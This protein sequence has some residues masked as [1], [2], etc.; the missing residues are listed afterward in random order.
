MKKTIGLV[1]LL[2][3]SSFM[4]AQDYFDLPT[5]KAFSFNPEAGNYIMNWTTSSDP[6]DEWRISRVAL[7]D[8]F[9]F[10]GSQ[11]NSSLSTDRKYALWQKLPFESRGGLPSDFNIQFW[12]YR[13]MVALWVDGGGAL[14]LPSASV[15]DACHR[16]GIKAMANITFADPTWPTETRWHNVFL[17][18]DQNKY[19]HA[20]KLVEILKHYGLDGL[21]VNFEVTSMSSTSTVTSTI[22]KEWLQAVKDEAARLGMTGFEI[23]SYYVW[24]NNGTRSWTIPGIHSDNSEWMK[25]NNKTTTTMALHNYPWSQTWISNSVT[26][27]A[28]IGISSYDSYMGLDFYLR[29]YNN[30]LD[31]K[32]SEVSM[33][34][35]GEPMPEIEGLPKETA[36]EKLSYQQRRVQQFFSGPNEDP[37]KTLTPYYCQ[38]PS[39]FGLANIYPARS[40]I[41]SWPFY[42]AFNAGIGAKYFAEGTVVHENE[43]NDMGI[44]DILPTWMWWWSTGGDGLTASLDYSDS[45]HGGSS[46]KI[47]GNIPSGDNLLRLYKT[48]LTV[49]ANSECVVTYK[50][51]DSANAASN[52]KLAVAFKDGTGISAFTYLPLGTA[53]SAGW[54]AKTISLASHVG[55]TLAVVGLNVVGDA[56][57]YTVNIGELKLTNGAITTPSAPTNLVVTEIDVDDNKFNVRLDWE[58]PSDPVLNET[59]NVDFFNIYE[60]NGTTNT[61]K[62]IGKSVHRGFIGRSIPLSAGN[63]NLQFQVVGV[64]KDGTT[65]STAT[66]V[67]PIYANF[68]VDNRIIAPNS[69]VTLTATD[70]NATTYTWS[71]QGATTTTATGR[72]ASFTFNNSGI[73]SVTLTV[74]NSTSTESKTR[75]GFIQVIDGHINSVN[76]A[77]FAADDAEI[78]PNDQVSFSFT[79]NNSSRTFKNG[80]KLVNTNKIGIDQAIIGAGTSWSYSWWYRFDR[81]PDGLSQFMKKKKPN[82]RS[83]FDLYVHP[84]GKITFNSAG[85][86]DIVIPKGQIKQGEWNL[87]TMTY[88]GTTFKFYLNTKSVFSKVRTVNCTNNPGQ[89][90][91]ISNGPYDGTV[92]EFQL[93]NRA[94][95]ATEVATINQQYTTAPAGLSGY[96]SFDSNT[97][98]INSNY[99]ATVYNGSSVLT[100]VNYIQGVP[101]F[102]KASTDPTYDWTFEGGTPSTSTVEAPVVTYSTAGT[103]DVSLTMTKDGVTYTETKEDYITVAAPQLEPVT[104]EYGTVSV[105]AE[106]QTVSLDSTYTDMVVVTTP[107]LNSSSELPA[108]VRVRNANTTSFDIKLQAAGSHTLT[109]NRTVHYITVEQGSYTELAH[110]VK[111]EAYK[112]NSANTWYK[113]A[114]N[115][116]LEQRSYVNSYTEPV[117][118]GQVMTNNDSKWSVFLCSNNNAEPTTATSFYAGKQVGEDNNQT[119][120]DETIG[121]VVIEKGTGSIGDINYVASKEQNLVGIGTNSNGVSYTLAQNQLSGTLTAIACVDGMTRSNG[122]WANLLT[123]T[124]VSTS[125]VQLVIDEDVVTDVERAHGTE[126]V[127]Y[128]ILGNSSLKSAP[129]NSS[130]NSIYSNS[131]VLLYPC[132]VKNKLNIVGY[133]GSDDIKLYDTSGRLVKIEKKTS[134]VLDFSNLPTGVYVVHLGQ[135]KKVVIKR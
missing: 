25:W 39:K 73:Y 63:S 128:L 48:Q 118:I 11:V 44:G 51:S 132:P 18:D 87:Y 75:Y 114:P 37:S 52:L 129:I 93:W 115:S 111:M 21:T 6:D 110:G 65:M 123:S 36:I 16:N 92:D 43:W 68:S 41:Q 86:T 113:W 79:G 88:D 95:S 103:Y 9:V 116:Q 80:I 61:K 23:G 26:E 101:W 78:E 66:S 56:E 33:W 77:N 69:S 8:R 12:Q 32:N 131:D 38:T 57:D 60:V 90:I 28:R 5:Q 121:Y 89:Q 64:G 107:V 59:A 76:S 70:P 125:I 84:T 3:I 81:F 31:F 94:L 85:S 10:S 108:V 119:R 130:K 74:G 42:T 22:V 20:V 54:N 53:T 49:S 30:Y 117:V 13:D 91:F 2:L 106:W 135:L 105:G 102:I 15:V 126:G 67:I 1:F 133:T 19:K 122:G 96:W 134:A 100:D 24:R 104:L 27:C 34:A 83:D 127:C 17:K 35:W 99:N 72:T 47:T 46:V 124:P 82:R 50:V 7:A 14:E 55:K 112:V 109:S 120:S 98:N 97:N 62:L 29:R 40:V 71:V 45:Y 58:L 4:Y